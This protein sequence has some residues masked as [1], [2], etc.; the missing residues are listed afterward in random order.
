MNR[1]RLPVQ[2][3]VLARVVRQYGPHPTSDLLGVDYTLTAPAD[4]EFPGF[5]G[6]VEL[7]VRNPRPAAVW[8]TITR[9][10]PDGTDR[11]EVFRRR[12]DLSFPTHANPVMVDVGL[13]V[14]NLSLPGVSGYAVRIVRPTRRA[15]GRV[16]KVYAT[17]FFWVERGP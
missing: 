6:G 14:P 5:V 12:F 16:S 13:K 17:E 11:A 10:W 3:C 1:F 8:V 2:H 7:F 15:V 9:L 4:T